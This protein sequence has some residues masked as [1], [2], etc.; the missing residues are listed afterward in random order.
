[1]NVSKP[2]QMPTADPKPHAKS[3]S[4]SYAK[5]CFK[6]STATGQ[7]KSSLAKSDMDVKKSNPSGP[8][9]SGGTTRIQRQPPAEAKY[10]GS[11]RVENDEP[12]EKEEFDSYSGSD[13]EC[14][15]YGP[16][17][18]FDAPDIRVVTAASGSTD[19][20]NVRSTIKSQRNNFLDT[21]SGTGTKSSMKTSN[22]ALADKDSTSKPTTATINAR[23]E[24]RKKRVEE[25]HKHATE[26]V[27]AKQ[28]L[29]EDERR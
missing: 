21:S 28:K 20:N 9:T 23:A 5:R 12:Y 4:T 27:H 25:L 8:R 2:N 15:P 6:S 10:C 18:A 16:P 19:A 22:G 26:R 7:E 29:L 17:P 1:M 3:N 14:R 24:E 11:N 13:E